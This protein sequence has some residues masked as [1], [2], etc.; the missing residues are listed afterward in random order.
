MWE[1]KWG[2]SPVDE[3]NEVIRDF[4]SINEVAIY[5]NRRFVRYVHAP[6]KAVAC[7]A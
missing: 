7:N 6:L 3:A 2:C 4:E 5:R 1:V